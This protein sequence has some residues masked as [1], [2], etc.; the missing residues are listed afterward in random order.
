MADYEV[1]RA[2]VRRLAPWLIPVI[3][4]YSAIGTTSTGI[5]TFYHQDVNTNLQTPEDFAGYWL[6][7]PDAALAG[8]RERQI[9]SIALATGTITH[10]GALYTNAPASGEQYEIH[11]LRPRDAF[12]RLV[13]V[14]ENFQLPTTQALPAFTDADQETSGV[15]NWTASSATITKITTAANVPAGNV[16]A[17]RVLL[18]GASGYSE[19]VTF[20]VVPGQSYFVSVPCR[21]DVGG[22]AVLVVWDKTNNVEIDSAGRVSHSLERFMVIQRRFTTPATCKE[23]AVRLQGTANT[24]DTYWGAVHGPWKSTDDAMGAPSWLNRAVDLRKLMSAYYGLSYA[25]GVYDAGSRIYRQEFYAGRDYALRS[26][27]AQANPFRI[28]MTARA[29]GAW[30]SDERWVEA[31]RPAADLYT[32]AFTAAGETAPVLNIDKRFLALEWLYAESETA[33]AAGRRPEQAKATLQAVAPMLDQLRRAYQR[34]LQ[35]PVARDEVG[36]WNFTGF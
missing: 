11:L 26:A 24:D 6:L 1:L 7:R 25:S 9:D 27:P 35:T 14:M 17:Q 4:T 8:D 16:Q 33:L 18:T 21:V 5:D 19:S 29:R 34:D 20:T 32:L 3:G 30:G 36:A 28:E 15:T 23:A 2:E 13:S 31:L 22:P 12:D 10:R